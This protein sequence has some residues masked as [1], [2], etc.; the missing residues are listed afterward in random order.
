MFM[1]LCSCAMKQL[2]VGGFFF[3]GNG[4]TVLFMY[5]RLNVSNGVTLQLKILFPSY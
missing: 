3:L 1:F 5:R 4:V 2:E